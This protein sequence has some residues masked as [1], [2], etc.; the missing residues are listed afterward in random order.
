[1]AGLGRTVATRGVVLPSRVPVPSLRVQPTIQP[2]EPTAPRRTA[3][4]LIFL[5]VCLDLLRVGLIVPLSP[6]IVERFD[7][8]AMAVGWLAM[9]YS[10]AQ[11][12]ATP[13]LGVLSDRFGRRPVLM[14]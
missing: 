7:A 2:A 12:L 3:S 9:S 11:F 5:I 6:Y 4:A 1:A 14:W 13:V 10:A 8:S